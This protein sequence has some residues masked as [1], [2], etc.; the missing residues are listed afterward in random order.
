[1]SGQVTTLDRLEPGDRALVH[2]VTGDRA[3]RRRL[4]DMGITKGTEIAVLR[5]SPLGDPVEYR[6]RNYHLSL[7]RSEARMIE[8][9]P[10]EP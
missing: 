8:V 9:T 1:M 4:L 10:K 5:I 3:I 6:L 7:R 2:R